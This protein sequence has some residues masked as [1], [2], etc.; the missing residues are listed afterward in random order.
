MQLVATS[1]TAVAVSWR[2]RAV[3]AKYGHKTPS[4]LGTTLAVPAG[5]TWRRVSPRMAYVELV[6]TPTQAHTHQLTVDLAG[7]AGCGAES[8]TAAIVEADP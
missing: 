4:R 7:L 1:E 6:S 8:N 2:S 5:E 3:T